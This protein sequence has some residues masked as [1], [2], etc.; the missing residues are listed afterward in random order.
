MSAI[1]ILSCSHWFSGASLHSNDEVLGS[2]P[3]MCTRKF[4]CGGEGFHVEEEKRVYHE[5]VHKKGIP[6]KMPFLEF[7]AEIYYDE[8]LKIVGQAK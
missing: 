5:L 7:W 1:S 8:A 6:L 3:M 4:L 2:M